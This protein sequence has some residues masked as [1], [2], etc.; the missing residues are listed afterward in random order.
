MDKFEDNMNYFMTARQEEA[1]RQL[2]R[3]N[4][5]YD[6]LRRTHAAVSERM[7][8]IINSL[9]LKEQNFTKDYR[10]DE[11]RIVCMERD[12]VYLQGYQDCIRLL[13]CVG[14]LEVRI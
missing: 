1:I 5:E 2:R 9:S 4:A 8:D 6:E 11:S 7:E 10:D 14:I 3:D 12:Q 13:A